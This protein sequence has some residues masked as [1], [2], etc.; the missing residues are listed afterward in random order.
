MR[1]AIQ[2][3]VEVVRLFYRMVLET[4]L[5]IEWGFG[6]FF[7]TLVHLIWLVRLIIVASLVVVAVF[8]AM[9]YWF[10]GYYGGVVLGTAGGL[11]IVVVVFFIKV[12][13]TDVERE[14]H[15]HERFK[16][17]VTT[18]FRYLLRVLAIAATVASAL[19][20]LFGA[21]A[22]RLAVLRP[23]FDTVEIRNECD[24]DA[25]VDV[26]YEDPFTGWRVRGTWQV[27]ALHA[28]VLPIVSHGSVLG[29]HI[30]YDG[31]MVPRQ[32]VSGVEVG[33]DQARLN[34]STRLIALPEQKSF[35]FGVPEKDESRPSQGAKFA[36]Y[37][38]SRN[39]ADLRYIGY[40]E[41]VPKPPPPAAAPPKKT[42]QK[43][44]AS[45]A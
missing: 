10:W 37:V 38:T 13:T 18:A 22:I 15:K 32:E 41:N 26:L 36:L 27:P 33:R 43:A 30:R 8:A 42:V 21:E 19:Y 9:G 4:Y 11:L 3:A 23:L 20:L 35:E 45:P 39:R 5:S 29:L 16:E 24:A 28:D 2:A 34:Y 1:A 17:V 12:D 14:I 25:Y 31:G 44:R 6:R 7:A 40:C